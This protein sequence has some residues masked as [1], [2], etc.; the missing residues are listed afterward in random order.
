MVAGTSLRGNRQTVLHGTICRLRL[1]GLPP[2]LVG[3][4]LQKLGN[5]RGVVKIAQRARPEERTVTCMR[6]YI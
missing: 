3:T 5:F 6:F 2:R 4:R 1:G